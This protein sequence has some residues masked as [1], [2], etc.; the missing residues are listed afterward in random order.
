MALMLA[1]LPLLA[2]TQADSAWKS[3]KTAEAERLYSVILRGD[4][5]NTIA[6]HRYALM[7]AWKNQFASSLH[8][9]DR[10]IALNPDNFEARVDR[11]RVL[12]WSGNLGGA[13][14][15]V[16]SIL[17]AHPGDL[18]ALQLRAQIDSWRGN[19]VASGMVYDS[20]LR[21]MPNDVT[22]LVSYA[23]SLRW[24]GRDAESYELLQRAL[25]LSPNSNDAREQMRWVHA[26]IGPHLR[27]N[28]VHEHDSDGNTINTV[29]ATFT[30]RPSLRWELRPEAYYRS[31]KDRFNA[32]SASGAGLGVVRFIDPGWSLQVF[33]GGSRNFPSYR[34]GIATP[35]NGR[36]SGNINYAYSA[37]D[38]TA[39]L[40]EKK[41]A[42]SDL[43]A[44]LVAS[45]PSATTFTLGAST[46]GFKS[47]V[48]QLSNRRTA[49]STS[50]TH[51][52]TRAFTLGVLGR[53]FS[54]D[55][56]LNDG[57]FDPDFYG[58][59]ELLGR[60]RYERK[61]VA[62]NVEGL[63]GIQKVGKNGNSTGT[64]RGSGRLTYTWGIGR[65][66]EAFAIYA[67]SGLNQLSQVTT[68]EYRYHAFG[69]SANWTF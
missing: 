66:I 52:M 40:I 28:Y 21:A 16:D 34:A 43:N 49:A 63:P 69:L 67:N 1:P 15:A 39:L 5:S 9:F 23:Q 19:F 54:F 29:N 24:Q 38:A 26:T 56:D 33:G 61:R 27:P 14:R 17:V 60:I 11:A 50:L 68:S 12:S 2:Q 42:T 48:S 4:S 36:V 10:L 8:L 31:A 35:N 45:L 59:A 25:A 37:L 47:D 62:L 51:R 20:V 53:V 44:G 18:E 6:L 3:G 64:L 58:N 65:T 32:E 46:T 41:V 30:V 57:Y 22:T 55:K 7:Q 13:S